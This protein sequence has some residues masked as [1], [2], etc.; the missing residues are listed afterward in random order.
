MGGEQVAELPG[1]FTGLHEE[2]ARDVADLGGELVDAD[3]GDGRSERRGDD[4]P[5]S[6]TGG[7]VKADRKLLHRGATLNA[8]IHGLLLPGPV[9]RPW[10][11]G[12]A[13][14]LDGLLHSL[15]YG[16]YMKHC[17]RVAYL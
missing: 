4:D 6:I 2:N 13:S 12:Y 10:E 5:G 16:V 14:I 11:Q 9:D 1:E 7:V 17:V 15:S 8:G 3:L